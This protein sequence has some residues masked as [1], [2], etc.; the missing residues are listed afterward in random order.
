MKKKGHDQENDSELDQLISTEFKLSDY[1]A[2]LLEEDYQFI[3]KQYGKD[4][5]DYEGRKYRT[6]LN[7]R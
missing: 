2:D 7:M 1:I 3:D 4:E 6:L 5:D